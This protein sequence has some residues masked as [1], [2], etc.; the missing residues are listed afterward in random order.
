MNRWHTF[1]GGLRGKFL[2]FFAMGMALTLL[3]TAMINYY[4][5]YSVFSKLNENISNSNMNQ[6]EAEINALT[7]NIGR[8]MDTSL[9]NLNETGQLAASGKIPADTYANAVITIKTA[10]TGLIASFPYIDSVF[11]FVGDERIFATSPLNTKQIY[12]EYHKWPSEQI[13]NA[14]EVSTR[15]LSVLGGIRTNDL[16]LS[17]DDSVNKPVLMLYKSTYVRGGKV[18][19]AVN[20]LESQVCMCYSGLMNQSDWNVRILTEDGM[21]VSSYDK[22]ELGGIYPRIN[23]IDLQADG[24][25]VIRD[26]TV[27]Q[28]IWRKIDKAGLIAVC[29]MPL[30][31]YTRILSPLQSRTVV[32]FLLGMAITC[33]LFFLWMI[34]V[35]RPLNALIRNMRLAGCGDYDHKLPV[36]GR[37]E[38]SILTMQYNNMLD[39]LKNFQQRQKETEMEIRES[40]LRVLKNQINPHFLYNTLNTIRWMAVLIGA[41]NIEKCISALGGIIAPLYKNN[42]PTCMLSEELEIVR[43]YLIIMNIRYNQSIQYVEKVP[44]GLTSAYVMRFILQPLVENSIQHG[45]AE[46]GYHGVIILSAQRE[47]SCILIYLDDNGAGM[48]DE[49]LEQ[50]NDAFRRGADTGGI[51]ALNVC[52]RIRLRYGPDYGVWFEHAAGGGLRAVLRLPY[53]QAEDSENT[54]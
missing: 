32:I 33:T 48:G 4:T 15:E 40:E 2:F 49:A 54:G 27:L 51:G 31:S 14:V 5:T 12:A 45:F 26:D 22:T 41:D 10:V 6:I 38:L 1:W 34:R 3:V 44:A 21:I 47:G 43:Q 28:V 16:A 29:E 11:F 42:S 37:D 17:S 9:L 50:Y 36:K 30:Q 25:S 39:D 13:M 53:L 7:S 52:R 20:I 35:L 23:K 18:T 19:C 24:K 46:R 8:I